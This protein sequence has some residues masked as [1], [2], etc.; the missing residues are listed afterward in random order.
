MD[1]E[2]QDSRLK[3]EVI[4]DPTGRDRE[5]G[6]RS[7][8][9]HAHVLILSQ[10][11][12]P[13]RGAV[14][15]T[16]RLAAGLS[17]RRYR[18]TV[19]AGLPHY[20]TGDPYPGYG[21]W[22]PVVGYDGATRVIRTPLVMGSN[23]QP[24]RRILGGLSFL[25][26]SLIWA[27]EMGRIDIVIASV[28][29]PTTSL[30]GLVIAVLRRCPCILLLRDI[31]PLRS[32]RLRGWAGRPLGG[33][34]TRTFLWCYRKAARVVVVHGTEKEL[35]TAFK[36]EA[37]RIAVISHGI[38]V[39]EY[40]G[41]PPQHCS[42]SLPRRNNRKV[43][44]YAGTIGIVHDLRSLILSAADERV[45]SLPVDFIIVGDGQMRDECVDLIERLALDNVVML[46]PVPLEEV[47]SLLSQA[48]ILIC[49]YK[50]EADG[51][52]GA[53]VY[54]Y[55]AAGK[56]IL[57]HGRSVAF[58][59]IS[60]I[61]NGLEC[62]SGDP[63]SLHGAL[64]EFLSRWPFWGVRG[65]LGRQY[66]VTNFSQDHRNEQWAELLDSTIDAARRG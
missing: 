1:R 13:E 48:D 57:I 23:R 22:K 37:E 63:A 50:A 33:A 32:F 28:P 20:P 39:E 41:A 16:Q 49:S 30:A 19:I 64:S 59:L 12:P 54:E 44:L 40:S 66:A 42:V 31:E 60:E 24:I 56:P 8:L 9:P 52:M 35:L 7:S 29:P 61:G 38:Y 6:Q 36:V 58:Q 45:R 3:M 18:V 11:Y 17:S 55:C 25:L 14:R 27:L 47:P 62:A 10:Y 2:N 51:V 4:A 46:P 21:R 5:S 34:V 26:S 53:K 65:A 43:A 15:Y